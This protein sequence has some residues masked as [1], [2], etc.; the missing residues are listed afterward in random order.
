MWQ[1]KAS[2]GDRI[3]DFYIPKLSIVEMDLIHGH[4]LCTHSYSDFIPDLVYNEKEFYMQCKKD[5]T[6]PQL[7]QRSGSVFSGLLG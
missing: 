2:L 5:K 1:N 4:N 6:L 3:I 7:A